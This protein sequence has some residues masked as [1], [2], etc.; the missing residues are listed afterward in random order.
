MLFRLFTIPSIALGVLGSAATLPPREESANCRSVCC[1]AIVPSIFPSGR[2]GINCHWD[3]LLDCGFSGQ[4]DSCCEA[5]VPFGVK[6]GT[7]IRC[8][9]R[10]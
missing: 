4:V 9:R 7:G 2:V 5:I 1:D 8:S 6:D 10:Q 3:E